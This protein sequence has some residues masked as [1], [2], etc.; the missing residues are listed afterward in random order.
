[1]LSIYIFFVRFVH[2]KRDFFPMKNLS[3]FNYKHFKV[4]N[5]TRGVSIIKLHND[6]KKDWRGLS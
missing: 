4:N 5:K 6:I 1:M 2:G 3:N